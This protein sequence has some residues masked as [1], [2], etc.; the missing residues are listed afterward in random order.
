MWVLEIELRSSERMASVLLIA[1]SS[2]QSLFGEFFIG[3]GPPFCFN[4]RFNGLVR[5]L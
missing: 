3:P 4:G 5:F 1:E 2:L